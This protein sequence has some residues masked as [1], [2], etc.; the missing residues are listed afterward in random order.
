MFNLPKTTPYWGLQCELGMWNMKSRIV[1]KRMM[2]LQSI[3]RSADNRIGKEIIEDQKHRETD[4]C[5]YS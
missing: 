4:Q 2:L 1:Y 5:W 3:A